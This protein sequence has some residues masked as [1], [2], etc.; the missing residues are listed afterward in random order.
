MQQWCGGLAF[1]RPSDEADEDDSGKAEDIH[2]KDFFDPAE[3]VPEP[4]GLPEASGAVFH[5]HMMPKAADGMHTTL[6]QLTR[7][8]NAYGGR[9]GGTGQYPRRSAWC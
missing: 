4:Q 3:E 5:P 1:T 7:T 2:Y 8:G 9:H 6:H